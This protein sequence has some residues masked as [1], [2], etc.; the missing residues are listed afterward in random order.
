[1]VGI[2]VAC[3]W[4]NTLRG[5]RHLWNVS[6]PISGDNGVQTMKHRI[7]KREREFS[8]HTTARVSPHTYC[9]QQRSLAEER[10]TPFTRNSERSI[11]NPWRLSIFCLGGGHGLER[12]GGRPLGCWLRSSPDLC[13]GYVGVNICKMSSWCSLKVRAPHSRPCGMCCV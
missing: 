11:M 12:A 10:V 7:A 13:G 6:L 9:W 3:V 8:P 4:F 1:M 2:N 5:F